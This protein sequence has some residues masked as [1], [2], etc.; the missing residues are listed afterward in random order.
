MPSVTCVSIPSML[1][2]T[3]VIKLPRERE[4]R[5]RRDHGTEIRVPEVLLH[6]G[7]CWE[8]W[9]VAGV[10]ERVRIRK[11]RW[12]PGS[13]SCLRVN[14]VHDPRISHGVD[15]QTYR[16]LIALPCGLRVLAGE[17]LGRYLQSDALGAKCLCLVPDHVWTEIVTLKVG[18]GYLSKLPLL[19]ILV[20]NG[21][22]AFK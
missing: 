15:S 8:N 20:L 21:L 12:S 16:L 2:T 6:S 3:L 4:K 7:L 17:A 18:L 22:V 13:H 9:V 14:T 5:L 1:W 10:G 11:Y 19:P